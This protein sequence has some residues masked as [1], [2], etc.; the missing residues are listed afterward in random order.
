MIEP[1]HCEYHD[2]TYFARCQHCDE[3]RDQHQAEAA[4]QSEDDQTDE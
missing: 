2:W 4:Q 1:K 3:E